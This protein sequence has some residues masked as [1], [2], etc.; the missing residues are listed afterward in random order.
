M[1]GAALDL[2]YFIPPL[3]VVTPE[4]TIRCYLPDDGALLVDALNASYAH[5]KTFMPWAKPHTTLEEAAHTARRFH[6]RYLLGED[7]VLGIFSPEGDRQLGSTGFHLREGGLDNRAA[8]TGMWIRAECAGQGLGTRVL[9][10]MLAWGFTAWP[11][12]RL[13][14]RC[15]GRNFASQ[16]TAEKA[17]LLREGVL[18]GRDRLPDGARDDEVCYAALRG[19]WVGPQL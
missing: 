13:S 4:F 3:E 18:R 17:G 9:V 11:W 14:W 15:S 19:E 6:A 7:F 12:E 2:K 8:E 10:A 16:R 5:L 1:A